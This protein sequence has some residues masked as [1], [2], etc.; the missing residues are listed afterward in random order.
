M[1]N[2]SVLA[3]YWN[4]T[5][6]F[7]VKP[8]E[9]E[10]LLGYLLRLDYING[11]FPG[12]LLKELL[13]VK[14]INDKSR[15]KYLNWEEVFNS[16]AFCKILD[17]C[18]D[19][20]LLSQRVNIPEKDIRKLTLYDAQ[21]RLSY[22]VDG[23]RKSL[24]YYSEL[25]ICPICIRKW[26]IPKYFLVNGTSTC[27]THGVKLIKH[28]ICG[29]KINLFHNPWNSLV[30]KNKVC[31]KP[32]SLQIKKNSA[33]HENLN[34]ESIINTY[35]YDEN[36]YIINIDEKEKSSEVLMQRLKYL[37]KVRI[38]ALKH[39]RAKLPIIIN[40][41][42]FFDSYEREIAE[43]NL[44]L[45]DIVREIC[46]FKL[47]P[48]QFAQINTSLSTQFNAKII[49]IQISSIADRNLNG[50]ISDYEDILEKITD[51]S[52]IISYNYNF[53][54]GYKKKDA[55]PDGVSILGEIEVY[56]TDFF[57]TLRFRIFRGIGKKINSFELY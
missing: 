35:I 52:K 2:D 17:L 30:C 24:V 27:L 46:Y 48:Y 49:K 18:I 33:F 16:G 37:R 1:V 29:K 39:I 42:V 54:V 8:F 7:I 41:P 26:V 55:I 3:N 53:N 34:Y 23:Q 28:C 11:F 5:L 22:F 20:H 9:G 57:T 56:N 51:A 44:N 4:E 14:D 25:K 45:P 43:Y 40:K 10:S 21:Q 36:S 13:T 32:Y 38:F 12:K 6:P 50:I 15:M 47:T 19:I 31:K